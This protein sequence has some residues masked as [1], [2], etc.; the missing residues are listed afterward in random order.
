MTESALPTA[1]LDALH[2]LTMAYRQHMR[3]ALHAQA[4]ALTPNELKVLLFVG[5]RPLCTHKDVVAHTGADKAQVA[6]T[7]LHMEAQGWLQRVPHPQDRR[8]RC[9]ELSARGSAAFEA[10]RAHRR[11][12]GGHMLQDASTD[13]QRQLLALLLHMHQQLRD[14]PLPAGLQHPPP[15]ACD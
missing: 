9:L 4:L 13:Q 2:D 14:L 3:A 10:L 6:R 1:V 7:L 5:Q 11:Q 12:L 15:D 8:S